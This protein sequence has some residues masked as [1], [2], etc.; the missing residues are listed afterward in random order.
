MVRITVLYPNES[1]KKFDHDYYVNKHM[2]L[3]RDRL[4]AFGLVRTEVDRGQAGGAPGSPAPYI[5]LGHV[6]FNRAEDFAKGMGQHGQEIM[7]DIANYTSI[8]PQI[9]ISEIIG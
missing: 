8:Q 4:G 6:Y 9:Q 2:K 5:A 3:V 7:A 1:G